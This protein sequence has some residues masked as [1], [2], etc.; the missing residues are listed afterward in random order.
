[1]N[2]TPIPILRLG[3]ILLA[4]LAGELDDKTAVLFGEELAEQIAGCSATGVLLDVSKLEIIDSFAARVLTELATAAGLLGARVVI[5]GM[6]PAVAVTLVHLGVN[7]PGLST[8]L[9]AEQ[10]MRMLTTAAHGT[11]ADGPGQCPS[12]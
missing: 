11:R 3:R 9:N 4:G 7:L 2:A 10:G 6:Q 5:A 12:R 8:A 1:M